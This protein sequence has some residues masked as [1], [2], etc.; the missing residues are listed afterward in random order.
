MWVCSKDF[1]LINLE[2]IDNIEINLCE[3]DNQFELDFLKNSEIINFIFYNNEEEL[4]RAYESIVNGL[5][6][7]IKVLNI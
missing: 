5:R 7:N 3:E 2:N 6:N 4:K 1:E